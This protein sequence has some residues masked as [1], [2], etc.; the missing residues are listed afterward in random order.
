MRPGRSS[1]VVASPGPGVFA[2]K[3]LSVVQAV[4]VFCA[5]VTVSLCVLSVTCTVPVERRR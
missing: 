2:Y 3:W 4:A 1:C 5:A